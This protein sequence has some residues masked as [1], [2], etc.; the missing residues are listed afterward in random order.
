[1]ITVGG[2][3]M[4]EPAR[5]RAAPPVDACPPQ[6]SRSQ[7][8]VPAVV[9]ALVAGLAVVQMLSGVPGVSGNVLTRNEAALRSGDHTYAEPGQILETLQVRTWHPPIEPDREVEEPKRSVTAPLTYS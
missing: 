4:E 8:P 6:S 1:M 3:E 9:L 5:Q 7:R 2:Q